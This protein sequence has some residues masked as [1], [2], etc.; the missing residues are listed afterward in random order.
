MRKVLV[1]GVLLVL[2]GCCGAALAAEEPHSNDFAYGYSLKVPENGAVYSLPLPSEVYR[3]VRRADLGDIRVFNSAGEA[4]PHAFR[5][6]EAAEETTRT[7]VDVPYFP[8]YE[9]DEATGDN[10]SLVVRRDADG[11]IIDIDSNRPALA[12]GDAQPTGYLLDL[13]DTPHAAGHLEV[14]WQ[15][16]TRQTSSSVTVEQSP[17]LQRWWSLAPKTTLVDLEYE[18]NRVEQRKIMLTQ[19]TE[20][21]LKI[22]WQQPSQA[23][24]FTRVVAVS[25]PLVSRQN[26]QWVTLYNG[27]KVKINSSTAI[28]FSSEYRLPVHSARLQ[29]PEQNSIVSA[30]LQ[31]RA[32]DDEQWR[33]QCSGVFYSLEM[34]GERLQSE[35]CSFRAT[36]DRLWRLVVLDDGAGLSGGNRQVNLDLGWLSDELLFLARGTGPYLLAYGNGRLENTRDLQR[37]DM[38]LTAIQQQQSGKIVQTATL[39]KHL[40]LGGEEAL[41]EP[42]PPKPWKTWLLWAV[43]VTGVIA[44]AMMAASLLKD[45]RRKEEQP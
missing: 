16:D 18:G 42:P 28:D 45:L 25:K 13:G 9:K 26:L 29:F 1:L 4:V 20:R 8:L 12:Q 7:S 33:E 19:R 5:Q 27:E 30:S 36:T 14:Y 40:E 37:T 11:T 24:T 34:A 39:G 2:C 3:K 22:L 41:L 21:Y 23:L 31:S 10:M 43:L 32:G 6:L 15:S 35:P 44:M 38:V 17:D